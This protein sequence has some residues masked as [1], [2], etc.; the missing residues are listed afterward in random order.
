[1]KK[2]SRILACVLL[3]AMLCPFLLTDSFADAAEEEKNYTELEDIDVTGES[4]AVIT[5]ILKDSVDIGV[6]SIEYSRYHAAVLMGDGTVRAFFYGYTDYGEP[7]KDYGQCQVSEWKNIKA[8]ACDNFCTYGLTEEGALVWVGEPD[9]YNYE[10]DEGWKKI[11]T[12]KGYS[13]IAIVNRMLFA[14]KDDGTIDIAFKEDY[15]N[16]EREKTYDEIEKLTDIIYMERYNYSTVYLLSSSG[17]ISIIDFFNSS[18]VEVKKLA[19]CADAVA[20]RIC[21][22][23]LCAVTAAGEYK[24]ID[25]SYRDDK[26]SAE[27]MFAEFPNFHINTDE[28]KY[29]W[30]TPPRTMGNWLF[31]DE[32]GELGIIW[33]RP[34]MQA[35]D[36]A[37]DKLNG[38]QDVQKVYMFEF[39]LPDDF[40]AVRES[41][42]G[43][44]DLQ[45]NRFY[46]FVS[47]GIIESGECYADYQFVKQQ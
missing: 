9:S 25:N 32:D 5:G 1:M 41:R 29:W 14:L 31:R 35:L 27:K 28:I 18:A 36:F 3:P 43:I 13:D 26:E 38:W 21:D 42:K 15:Y 6:K 44:Y 10:N 2:F 39:A 46:L 34:S 40:G 16:E 8:I 17:D 47:L 22:G 7:L 19:N 45:V 23:A 11:S 12:G 20:L 33:A 24:E 4:L 37:G 30:V